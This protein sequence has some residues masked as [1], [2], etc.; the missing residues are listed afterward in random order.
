ML[1]PPR[2]PS[3]DELEALIKEARARQLH[4]RLLGTAALAVSAAIGLSVYAFTLGSGAPGG[5][6]NTLPHGAAPLCRS[7]QLSAAAIWDGA[8][9]HLFNFFTIVNKGR[10]ACLLPTGR[11][12]V[13]LTRHGSRLKVDERTASGESIFGPGKPVGI[14]APGRRAVVHLAWWNW[15]GPNIR[16]ARTATTVTVQFAEGPRMTVPH[17]LGQPPCMDSAQPSVLIVSAPMTPN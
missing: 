3:H 2:P 8:A 14:L 7:P 9:G 17:L 11:P 15:C 1:A 6:T 16:Y 10:G 12:A 4:R 5:V 13:L